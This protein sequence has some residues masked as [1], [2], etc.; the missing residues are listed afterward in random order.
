MTSR[1]MCRPEALDLMYIE[2]PSEPRSSSA[3]LLYQSTIPL[4]TGL[5]SW[6]TEKRFV[7][8]CV[9]VCVYIHYIRKSVCT[10]IFKTDISR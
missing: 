9:C 7:C 8:V 1:E 4:Q 6:E 3:Y 10:A 5:W 2:M